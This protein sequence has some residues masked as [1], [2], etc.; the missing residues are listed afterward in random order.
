MYRVKNEKLKGAFSSSAEPLLQATAF[1]ES[2]NAESQAEPT[3]KQIII[4]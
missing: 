1:T 4:E 2:G 3:N